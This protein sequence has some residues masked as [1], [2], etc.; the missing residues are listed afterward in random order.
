MNW[1]FVLL[2]V[3]VVVHALLL[4]L[5]LLAVVVVVVIGELLLLLLLLLRI[6]SVAL[7]ALCA[8]SDDAQDIEIVNCYFFAIVLVI[9]QFF[10]SI[11]LFFNAKE[12][13]PSLCFPF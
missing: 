11:I 4:L 8:R 12:T 10:N 1:L 7:H 3:V 13:C 2:F 6:M 5:L 9:F